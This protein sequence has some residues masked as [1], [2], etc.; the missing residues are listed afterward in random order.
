MPSA[1]ATRLPSTATLVPA[2]QS[3]DPSVLRTTVDPGN[4]SGGADSDSDNDPASRRRRWHA[5]HLQDLLLTIND[6]QYTN[7][8]TMGQLRKHLQ[9]VEQ[10]ADCRN[11][12]GK[13]RVRHRGRYNKLHVVIHGDMPTH[14]ERI[15]SL[16]H[17][18]SV[19]KELLLDEKA[20]ELKGRMQKES[21]G[22]SS[23]WVEWVREVCYTLCGA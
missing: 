10:L 18:G 21:E 20:D 23:G 11:G 12:S 14:L 6:F 8:T 2:T 9:D 5:K 1:S 16:N 3:T 4:K 22:G 17:L 7:R 13:T 15:E 19:Y